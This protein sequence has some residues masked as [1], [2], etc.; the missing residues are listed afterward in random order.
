MQ[1]KENIIALLF[2]RLVLVEL[3]YAED[4]RHYSFRKFK[5]EP[6]QE[7]LDAVDALIHNL[8]LMTAGE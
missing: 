2:Q 3:P 4:L 1:E 5:V 6:T 7:Q 8:D